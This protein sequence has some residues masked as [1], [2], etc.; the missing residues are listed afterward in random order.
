MKIV[1]AQQMQELDRRAIAG[2]I[3]GIELM[4]NA[5]RGTFEKIRQYFPGAFKQNIVVLCGRGNNGGDGF[6]IARCLHH[7]GARVK[8][9]LLA[10]ADRVSGDAR[11]NLDAYRRIG[12]VVQEVTDAAQWGSAVPDVQR[13]GLIV[14][15]MLGTGLSAEVTGLY[16]QA[17]EDIN[18]AP[19]ARI[20]SVD[21]PS[22]I[23]ATSGAVLGAAVRAHLTCTFGLPK[24]GLLIEPGASY[25]GSREVIDIGIPEM[26]VRDVV[27]QE[28]LL[29][30]Q[31]LQGTL[32]RRRHDAHKGSFGHVLIIAGS[33]G[34]TGAAALAGQAAMRAGAGLV[35]VAAPAALNPVLEAKLTEVMT[36]PLPDA[37]AGFLGMQALP[38]LREILQGK[39]VVALGPGLATKD[40][41]AELVHSLLGQITVPVVIDADGLNVL[42][43]HTEL[44]TQARSPVIVTP[45]PGEMARL[46][47]VSTQDVQRDRI[48]SARTF[49]RRYG[50]FVVLKGALSII[51][52]PEGMVF[53]NPTGNPGMASGG[54]G[55]ALTGLIAGL[56][57]QGLPLT[58]AAQLAVFAH[59]RIGDGIARNKAPVGII[60]TDIIEGI[61]EE[62]SRFIG[63]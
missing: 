25:T 52:E 49:A 30:E 15:A 41:T 59:G 22:G 3:P 43:G 8:V 27:T 2:G 53:I 10:T 14:D 38:R 26:L 34:K 18:A 62:L 51:A 55:D 29:D 7:A 32:P 58:A 57:A 11:T 16:R 4:E 24:R 42:A 50:V 1:S 12:G 35:T 37:G 31:Y 33:P 54:M 56:A 39:T 48:G 44:L 28:F 9:I 19:G 36:E 45:H 40:E 21:I 46:A 61:P 23:D 60:A 20:V 63:A 6:V 13:A 47:G 17:I 5:G